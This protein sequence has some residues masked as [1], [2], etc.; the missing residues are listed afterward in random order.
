MNDTEASYCIRWHEKT[1]SIVK[2]R[3]GFTVLAYKF[4]ET[5]VEVAPFFLWTQV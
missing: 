3:E 4:A 5:G 1:P 2:N